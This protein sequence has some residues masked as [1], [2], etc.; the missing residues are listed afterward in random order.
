MKSARQQ[1]QEEEERSARL[2]QSYVNQFRQKSRPFVQL[3]TAVHDIRI[4]DEVMVWA[5]TEGLDLTQ[6]CDEQLQVANDEQ[7]D[8]WANI[9]SEARRSNALG[10][11]I[12]RMHTSRH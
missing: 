9:V 5:G 6:Q 1:Q 8:V 2:L 12:H 4:M 3:L 10:L 11:T 7:D